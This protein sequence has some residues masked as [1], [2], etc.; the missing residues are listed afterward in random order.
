[1]P[2]FLVNGKNVFDKLQQAK[3]HFVVFANDPNEFHALEKDFETNYSHTADFNLFSLSP[4]VEEAFGT[5]NDFSVLLR[6]DNHVG[7]ISSDISL[8]KFRNY[9]SRFIGQSE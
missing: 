6:P 4:E 1:M 5:K 8:S 3:F 9:M 7:F 2:Y